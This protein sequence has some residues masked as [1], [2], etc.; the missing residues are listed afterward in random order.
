MKTSIT[1]P[2][3][4]HSTNYIYQLLF[5]DNK[6]LF[7]LKT[8]APYSYPYDLLFSPDSTTNDLQRII[9]DETTDTRLKILAYNRQRELGH[10]TETPELLAV[11]V[12][13]GLENGLD[14]LAS[15][16]NGTARY[17]NHSGK[18]LIWETT[19]D[20]QANNLTNTLFTC[21]EVVINRIG[22][23]D[24]P[25]R[26]HPVTGNV[27]LTFLVSDGLY[28]GEGPVDVLFRDPLAAPTLSA[29]TQ[30]MIFLT[31]KV[32]AGEGGEPVNV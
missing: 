23:W 25:R 1:G 32:T 18:L 24:K 2:Y 9:D 5:C 17:I 22:P 7:Q 29:A 21:G 16:Q 27:R 15:F 10:K 26:P 12:E 31:D 4:D 11:I 19:N 20:L 8:E 13:V 28:F 14:V 6:E 3:K 30:L